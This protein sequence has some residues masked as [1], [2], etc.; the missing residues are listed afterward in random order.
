MWATTILIFGV[1]LNETYVEID[2]KS[3]KTQIALQLHNKIQLCIQNVKLEVKCC[4]AL[5]LFCVTVTI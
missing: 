1:Y 4:N 5:V 3:F 2:L